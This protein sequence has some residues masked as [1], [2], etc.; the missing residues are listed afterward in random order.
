MHR[1]RQVLL[2]VAA[3][4]VCVSMR[5]D[6]PPGQMSFFDEEFRFFLDEELEQM[7]LDALAKMYIR[8]KEVIIRRLDE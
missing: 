7:S 4:V 2:D 6:P 8:F 5:K 3:L 1:A